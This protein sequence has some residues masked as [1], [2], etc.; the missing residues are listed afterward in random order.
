MG[1]GQPAKI[2]DR[3]SADELNRVC[4][5]IRYKGTPIT[6][7]NSGQAIVDLQGLATCNHSLMFWLLHYIFRDCSFPEIAFDE[8]GRT[9]DR[10]VRVCYKAPHPKPNPKP[11]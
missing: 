8:A 1:K 10:E 4:I 5:L 11:G 6:P 3:D 9:D 7:I 2:R